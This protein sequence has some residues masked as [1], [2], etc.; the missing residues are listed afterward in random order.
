VA[1]GE[2]WSGYAVGRYQESGIQ[3][4]CDERSGIKK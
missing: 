3:V 1:R 2:W 4:A